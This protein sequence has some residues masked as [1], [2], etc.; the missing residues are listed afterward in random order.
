MEPAEP[1]KIARPRSVAQII[2]EALPATQP[3]VKRAASSEPPVALP[4]L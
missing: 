2:G 4:A 1:N 3:A